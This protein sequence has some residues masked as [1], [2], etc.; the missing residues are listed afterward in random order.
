[1]LAEELKN[2][3][4]KKIVK[5]KPFFTVINGIGHVTPTIIRK[6]YPPIIFDV[7]QNK[8]NAKYNGEILEKEE[9]F[10]QEMNTLGN[11]AGDAG[12]LDEALG[13]YN[14]GLA[15][16]P[17]HS[18][19]LTAK[20]ITLKDFG[21]LDEA[22]EIF[23]KVEKLYPNT[24]GPLHNKGLTLALMGKQE[25]ALDY[26]KKAIEKEKDGKE[27]AEIKQNLE[28]VVRWGKDF[29]KRRKNIEDMKEEFHHY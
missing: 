25:E 28:D 17:K 6:K 24:A 27:L 1:M 20:G 16:N 29:V 7:S 4:G 22:L 13:C 19:L 14:K 2:E 23:D 5:A 3:Q 11:M 26:L 15:I 10:I 12:R 9:L 21:M 18:W 8:P